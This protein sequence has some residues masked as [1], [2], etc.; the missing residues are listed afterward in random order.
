MKWRIE[1]TAREARTCF[2]VFTGG[3]SPNDIADAIDVSTQDN[4]MPVLWD[5]IEYVGCTVEDGDGNFFESFASATGGQ[6]NPGNTVNTTFLVKKI[7]GV[8]GRK[9]RGRMYLP[10]VA[11]FGVDPNGVLDESYRDGVQAAVSAWYAWTTADFAGDMCILHTS[12]GDDPTD[13]LSLLVD[14]RAGSQRRRMRS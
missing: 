3:A 2:G 8:T 14:P 5:G 4:L 1:G 13:V 7:T 12:V 11:E 6:A 10:G 9:N